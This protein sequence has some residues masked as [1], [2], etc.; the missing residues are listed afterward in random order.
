MVSGKKPNLVRRKKIAQMRAKGLSLA[1]I[2]RRLG[3]S[4]QAV[5]ITVRAMERPVV[6]AVACAGC[7]AA[8]V[9]A[10]ALRSD[11]GAAL[12]LPCLR[13]KPSAPFGQRLKACRLAAGLTK[14]ELS[15]RTGVNLQVLRHYEAGPREPRWSQVARLVRVLGPALV[16]LGLTG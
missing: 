5:Q 12:C 2:G 7:G 4:R 8:V 15:R 3:V 14:V 13:R 9:S 16:T 6:R 10:G 1:E 11:R